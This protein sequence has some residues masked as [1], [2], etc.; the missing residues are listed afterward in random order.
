MA[1]EG[2]RFNYKFKPFLQLS[3]E[4]FI[5]M[6]FNHFRHYSNLITKTYFIVTKEQ[7]INNNIEE[8]MADMFENYK[9]IVLDKKTN[10]QY[11]TI[12]K[13]I[14]QENIIG[15]SFIC[16]CDHS[17]DISPIIDYL[18]K[19]NIDT[20]TILVPTWN[21][22]NE[23]KRAWGKIYLDNNNNVVNICEKE[24]LE[25]KDT[26]EYGLIGCYYFNNTGIIKDYDYNCLSELIKNVYV[27]TNKTNNLKCV[28]IENAFFFGDP[29]RLAEVI[30]FRKNQMCIFCDIDGTLLYHEGA[31]TYKNEKFLK[32]VQE[33]L[34]LFRKYNAK[35]IIT[36]ARKNTRK[37]ENMLNRLN[38]K[39]DGLLTKL[40]GGPRIVINDSKPNSPFTLQAL[41]FNVER[42]MGMENLSIDNILNNDK[43][44]T[45]FKGGSFSSVYCVNK[46]GI[47]VV[48]KII[49]KNQQNKRHYQKLKLQYNNIIRFN[50][51]M[52]N[53]CPSILDEVDNDYYY[54]YDMEYLKDYKILNEIDDKYLI[55]NR[56][57][58]TLKNE[59][60]IMKK[61]NNNPNWLADFIKKKICVAHYERLSENIGKMINCDYL[62]INGTRY[63]GFKKLFNTLISDHLD[64][65]NP[66]FL[67]PIHGDLTYGNIM[68][69]ENI[70]DI[71]ILDMD[72]G[73]Y[74]DAV[75]LD[76]GKLL[77]SELSKY[78]LWSCDEGLIKNIDF[79]NNIINSCEY[80]D[81]GTLNEILGKFGVWKDI[82]QV[83][84]T[85]KFKNIGIFYMIIHLLRMIPYRYK[86]GEKY[87]IYT[88]KEIVFWLNKIFI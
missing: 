71:K 50:T 63:N 32:G 16:D 74:I 79:E 66:K 69:N 77:Q 73:D 38:I 40:P 33:K 23:N 12:K 83:D 35:L 27:D 15:P 88:I 76:L 21:I 22:E 24:I 10:S 62:I 72:G 19:E 28:Q 18:K 4:T 46:N 84:D 30:N 68:Y 58:E 53:L 41:G 54:Y 42:D 87:A 11:E 81:M 85:N 60:Y 75:E 7:Y 9:V 80:L 37:V 59:I 1:G 51:Y 20:N 67:A 52:S 56:L 86:S 49:Y 55:L 26:Q 3:D 78:E 2:S 25:I 8:R 47:L 6:A 43:I 17:I 44:V 5:E 61:S 14:L 82:L 29:D 36:T 70:D 48:R 39:Y 57:F 34:E 31:P 64:Y 13:G 65:F 45:I